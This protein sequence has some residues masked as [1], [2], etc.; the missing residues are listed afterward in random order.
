MELI[1]LSTCSRL[2]WPFLGG[3]EAERRVLRSRF[4]SAAANGDAAAFGDRSGCETPDYLH[5]LLTHKNLCCSILQM[6]HD[7]V[8]TCVQNKADI[9]HFNGTSVVQRLQIMIQW[10]WCPG[11]P[12]ELAGRR[13]MQQLRRFETV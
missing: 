3:L 12:A 4:G 11:T 1:D 5:S 8:R 6:V 13:C 9:Y 2:L 10:S 7:Y